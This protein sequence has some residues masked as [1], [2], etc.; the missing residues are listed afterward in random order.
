MKN[1]QL[2]KLLGEA[3]FGDQKYTSAAS[4]LQK[5]LDMSGNRADAETFYKLGFAYFQTNENQKAIEN[6]KKVGLEKGAMGHISSFYLGQLYL[7]ERNLN[8]AY[9]A[10]KTVAN[11]TEDSEMRRNQL[12]PSER[13]TFKGPNM[14]RPLLISLLSS[15]S[16]LIADGR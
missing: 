13:S 8:Y 11:S 12:L 4:H 7:K 15:I 6:F 16:F 10:F 2:N 5:Y 1:K 3:Y 9:S 14:Q